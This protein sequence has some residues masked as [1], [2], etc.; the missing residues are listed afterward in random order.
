MEDPFLKVLLDTKKSDMNTKNKKHGRD[1]DGDT[2]MECKSSKRGTHRGTH[3]GRRGKPS[4]EEMTESVDVSSVKTFD[5]SDLCASPLFL[6]FGARRVGKTHLMTWLLSLMK[7]KIDKAYLFSNTSRVQIAA[8]DM[9]VPDHKFEG[10][11][12]EVM[13]HIWQE[14]VH[15]FEE[16]NDML[17][18]T[19][20]DKEERQRVIKKR[21]PKVFIVFDD[22]ISDERI[23]S[24]K[25]INDIFVM[26]RHLN[27]G[28]AFL[29]QAISARASFNIMCRPNVDYVIS[30][31]MNSRGDW[32]RLS[33]MYLSF[34]DWK[35]GF[36]L[37]KGITR[38]KYNFVVAVHCIRDDDMTTERSNATNILKIK[39]PAKKPKFQLGDKELWLS[40]KVKESRQR[41]ARLAPKSKSKMEMANIRFPKG[42]FIAG[43]D[44]PVIILPEPT[45][46]TIQS[47]RGSMRKR[48]I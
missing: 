34:E 15:K 18:P 28:A 39:A 41:K 20:P 6:V 16:L 25:V 22:I 24:R 32:E 33:E 2:A 17:E 46:N 38:T 7:D 42:G 47:L 14:Q 21:A 44:Q 48:K 36:C 3:R 27:I 26:G 35:L 23:R 11:Q 5:P 19:M 4:L 43:I 45:L 9:I 40:H 30:S 29:S 12:E 13:N 8:W 10:F 1:D 31:H 37:A